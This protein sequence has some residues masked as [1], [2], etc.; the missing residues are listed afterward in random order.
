M[1]DASAIA[2]LP[3]DVRVALVD[4][5]EAAHAALG[6]DLRAV[7]L[8]GPAAEARLRASSDVNLLLVA[9]ALPADALAALGAPLRL[10]TLAVRL[11]AMV[12]LESELAEATEA[13]AVKFADMHERHRVLY[14][15]DPLESLTPSR[16][17]GRRRLQQILLNFALRTRERF[18][19]A[20]GGAGEQA[21]IRA[22]AE[23]AAPLRSAGALLLALEGTLAAAPREA[24]ATL[25]RQDGAP[26][27]EQVLVDLSAAREQGA[28]PPGRP[29]TAL[30]ELEALSRRLRSRCARL[31]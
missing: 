21:L 29:G 3:A 24:L 4:F 14:G 10:G 31:I 15:T 18:M 6:F 19:L 17:A 25:S 8:F 20:S 30:L 5:V 22:L 23:A 26:G 1:I 28:L 13:F 9:G 16:E 7:V 11:T 27:W 12:I 2:D